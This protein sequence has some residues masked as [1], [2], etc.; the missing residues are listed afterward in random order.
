MT[1]LINVNHHHGLPVGPF[2]F[3]SPVEVLDF[4]EELGWQRGE[5]PIDADI[6]EWLNSVSPGA[7]WHWED[8]MLWLA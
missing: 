3:E 4:A 1:K 2:S 6:V 8:G 7:S 5:G